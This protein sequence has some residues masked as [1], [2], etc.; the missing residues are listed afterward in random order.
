MRVA[1]A[2]VLVQAV[3]VEPS[4]TVGTHMHAQNISPRS[5]VSEALG[6]ESLFELQ[7]TESPRDPPP[8]YNEIYPL[9]PYEGGGVWSS[10]KAHEVCVCVCECAS[11]LCNIVSKFT[12]NSYL[13]ICLS[14]IYVCTHRHTRTCVGPCSEKLRNQMLK[15]GLFTMAGWRLLPLRLETALAHEN[16]DLYPGLTL[17]VNVYAYMYT[18]IHTQTYVKQDPIED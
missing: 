9:P 16:G 4:L 5:N 6:S 14:V 17:Y 1:G 8:A 11:L 3:E 7:M 15:I 12:S 2:P 10:S 18:H 13:S